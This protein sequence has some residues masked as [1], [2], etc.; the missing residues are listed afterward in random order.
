MQNLALSDVE[1]SDLQSLVDDGV[2]ET[3]ELEFKREMNPHADSHKKKVIHEVIALANERGGDL[4]LGLDQDD[5]GRASEVCGMDIPDL[6]ETK[7]TW[8][9]IF[10]DYIEPRISPGHLEVEGVELAS[11]QS[12][13]LIRVQKSPARP[14]R[15]TIS[16]R[17]YRRTSS[18][19]QELSMLEIRRAILESEGEESF[20]DLM[21]NLKEERLNL[22]E[23]RGNN[24]PTPLPTGPCVVVHLFPTGMFDIDHGIDQRDLP[25][26]PLFGKPKA[27]PPGDLTGDGVVMTNQRFGGESP[28]YIY[29]SEKGYI[30]AVST[31]Y[32]KRPTMDAFQDPKAGAIDPV[33]A[34][35]VL[36]TVTYS[37]PRLDDI[38]AELP[39]YAHVTLLGVDGYF[40]GRNEGH[41]AR[42]SP[43]GLT[44]QTE[45]P[46]V[47][48]DSFDDDLDDLFETLGRLYQVDRFTPRYV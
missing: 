23:S 18:G 5:V 30:E 2:R 14:H 39:V 17:V 26:P 21:D 48:I 41:P 36:Q 8:N 19:L 11:G 40:M 28:N 47:P 46:V 13:I 37:M 3:K 27:V 34:N 35:D 32:F 29:F 38:G 12:V 20:E 1:E 10:R 25:L 16:R 22:I 44:D 4:I 24:L 9:D 42:N 45:L 7:G 15:N 6:D 33:L 43:G 31:E